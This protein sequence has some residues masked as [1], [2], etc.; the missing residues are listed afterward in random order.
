MH[1]SGVQ[2][3]IVDR[4]DDL[5]GPDG[6]FAAPLPRQPSGGAPRR[7]DTAG[8][9]GS[10]YSDTDKEEVYMHAYTR[11]RARAHTRMHACM[12]GYRSSRA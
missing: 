10:N 7:S 5:K 12:H 11:T 3:T 4:M 1:G 6:G 9:V 2:I 8:S